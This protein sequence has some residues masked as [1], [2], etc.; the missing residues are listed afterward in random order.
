M[1][2]LFAELYT[3][4]IYLNL[5]ADLLVNRDRLCVRGKTSLADSPSLSRRVLE[6]LQF[7]FLIE[8]CIYRTSFVTTVC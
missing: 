6:P 5:Y 3:V 1:G 8:Y 7:F 4:A 2:F